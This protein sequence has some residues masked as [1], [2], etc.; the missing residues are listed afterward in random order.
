MTNCDKDVG[1]VIKSCDIIYGW[2]LV[3]YRDLVT[4]TIIK[5]KSKKVN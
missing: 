1:G 4:N 2:P 5:I 3:S